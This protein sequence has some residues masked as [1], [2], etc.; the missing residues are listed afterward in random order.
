MLD[1]W[2]AEPA[3][4]LKAGGMGIREVRRAAKATDRSEAETAR[5]VELA[6]V[7]G[8]A[9]ADFGAAR[10]LPTDGL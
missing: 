8:L 10:A 6:A 1:Q 9:R 7:A 4:V 3:A 5:I 2:S